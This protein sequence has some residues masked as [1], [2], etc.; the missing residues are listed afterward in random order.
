MPVEKT[1]SIM[2]RKMPAALWDRAKHQ[3]VNESISLQELVIR[4]LREYLDK[5]NSPN[6]PSRTHNP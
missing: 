3:A 4:A 6:S 2:T 1:I 5:R